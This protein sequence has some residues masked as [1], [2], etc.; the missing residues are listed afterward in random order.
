MSSFA[1]LGA[2]APVAKALE[3]RN[4]IQAF[5]IQAMVIKDATAGRDVL[6]KSRTGSGKTL[7]FA[8]P[9]VDRIDQAAKR[10]AGLILVPTRE[11][12][13]QVTDEMKDI[14]AARN[15]RVA[16]VYGGVGL[17]KQAERARKAHIV[18]ATPGRLTDLVNR[19][20]LSLDNIQILVL[21][22]ADRML[23]MGFQPQVDK[24]VDKLRGRRQTMF[25][26]ATLDGTVGHLA[27]LYTHDPVMHEVVEDKPAIEDADHRFI[28]V[29]EHGKLDKLI[30]ILEEER[31]LA[32]V[33][34]RTKRGADRLASKLK[35]RHVSAL[36]LHGDMTQSARQKAL[37]RF[38]AGK[39]SVLVATDVAARGLDLDDI[40]HVINYDP[41][42]DHRDYVHR[43][44]RTAR[45][46]RS[47]SGVTF[48]AP[49]QAAEMSGIA[50]QLDLKEEFV[51]SGMKMSAPQTV[52][53]SK[54][55]R[56]SMR[57]PRKRRV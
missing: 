21:D 52:F 12:A 47:G 54:G 32:L 55:R 40:S 4:I 17:E 22:E 14:T 15:L 7:A 51:A 34:V 16:S 48:V 9:M 46:G 38:D 31:G 23:D 11:L 30:E 49:R 13:V 42:R 50:R 35:S 2:S 57:A 53:S 28:P 36:A 29:D 1:E 25:F 3:R 41:P 43:V 6:A 20:M 10:P 27:K 8:V 5:P 39:V 45:A 18:V 24:I 33:F 37:E 26:S 19:R 44:G 56:S